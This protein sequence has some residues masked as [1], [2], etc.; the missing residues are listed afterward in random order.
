[1]IVNTITDAEAHLSSLVEQVLQGEEVI[2]MLAGQP[3]TRLPAYTDRKYQ[4]PTA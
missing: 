2:I 3:V 1:M 4:L